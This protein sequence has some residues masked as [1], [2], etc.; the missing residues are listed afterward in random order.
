M[1]WG[2]YWGHFSILDNIGMICHT[3]SHGTPASYSVP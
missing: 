1:N 3:P 2:D